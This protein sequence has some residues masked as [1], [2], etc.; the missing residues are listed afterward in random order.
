MHLP[1]PRLQPY[2]LPPHT[3]FP[4]YWIIVKQISDLLSF[5]LSTRLFPG[6]SYHRNNKPS[7]L[8]PSLSHHLE[9]KLRGWKQETSPG[10]TPI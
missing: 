3:H 9:K 4:P 8:I 7:S 10:A 1:I 6:I 5:H 2:L